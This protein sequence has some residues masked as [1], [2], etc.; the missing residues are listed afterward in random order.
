MFVQQFNGQT[1]EVLDVLP[2][3]D[4]RD[5]RPPQRDSGTDMIFDRVLRRN[6]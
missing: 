4:G 3:R 1:A 2:V 5:I 6:P